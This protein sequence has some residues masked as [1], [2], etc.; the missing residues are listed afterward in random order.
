MTPKH[1]G[2]EWKVTGSMVYVEEGD[3]RTDI[4]IAQRLPGE[5][6]SRWAEE[7]RNAR[8]ISAAPELLAACKAILKNSGYGTNQIEAAI[9]KAEWTSTD[10]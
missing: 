8:L 5:G 10:F 9:A 4:A 2:G 6:L 7:L 3:R 1:T